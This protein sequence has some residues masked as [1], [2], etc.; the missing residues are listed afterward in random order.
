MNNEIIGTWAG[1]VWSTLNANGPMTVKDIR[2]ATR[3]REKDV[4]AAIGWLSR[5]NKISFEDSESKDTVISLG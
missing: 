2:K 3:L 4:Y 1:T 5:E